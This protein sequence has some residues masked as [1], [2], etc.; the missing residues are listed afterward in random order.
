[1]HHWEFKL[2]DLGFVREGLSLRINAISLVG[3]AFLMVTFFLQ[4]HGVSRAAQAQRLQVF[5]RF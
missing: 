1:L 2:V 3:T 5:P 4:H